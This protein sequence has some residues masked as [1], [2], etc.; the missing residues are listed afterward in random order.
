MNCGDFEEVVTD[1]ARGE[2][3]EAGALA[4]SASCAACAAKLAAE[5]ALQA[6]LLALAATGAAA[7]ASPRVEQALLAALRRPRRDWT[8][9]A[10]AAGILVVAAAATTTAVLRRDPAPK[11]VPAVTAEPAPVVVAEAPQPLPQA[12]RRAVPQAVRE[13]RTAFLPLLDGDDLDV[14]DGSH[15][16]R[17]RLPRSAMALVGLPIS[18]TRAAEPVHADV[19]LGADGLARA[20]RFVE[21]ERTP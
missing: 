8:W 1:L 7:E 16:V 21:K 14:L 19:L 3:T 13:I 15:L 11:P 9:I 4:H 12:P 2:I 18:E 17:V 5:Q 10:V 6:D 20:I